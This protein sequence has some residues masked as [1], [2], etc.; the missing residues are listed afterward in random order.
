MYACTQIR[1]SPKTDFFEIARRSS[2]VA[3]E[4]R[5]RGRQRETGIIASPAA[6]VVPFAWDRRISACELRAVQ[7]HDAFPAKLELMSRQELP[8]RQL[9]TTELAFTTLGLGTWAIGGGDWQFGWGPQD[10]REAIA[11][12]QRAVELG[13]NWID[14]AAVYGGGR[15]EELVGRAIASVPRQDRPYIATK[16]GRKVRSDGSVYGEIKRHSVLA[17]CDASL[18]R[19]DVDVIDLYQL[20]WP[21]PE[22]DIE[23]AWTSMAE[24]VQAGKVRHIG[25]SNHSVAQM[26][27]L[28]T[29]HPIASLQPPYSMVVRDAETELL[30]YCRQQG[31]GVVTYSPLYKG[32]LTGSFSPARVASLGADDHRSRDPRFHEP[33]LSVHL[34]LVDQLRQIAAEQGRTPGELAIAWI[35]RRPEI[36]SAIVGARRPAQID[37]LVAGG[38]WEFDEKVAARLDAALSDHASKLADS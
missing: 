27:R 6:V 34:A 7:D 14:T 37:A 19:L 11:T 16:C 2:Q 29:I 17:E 25:V 24:L 3:E 9:G 5:G 23:E 18:S 36:T 28:A 12:I 30:P 4:E 26:R 31:I 21:L 35:L 8:V 32:L 20:H 10:E 38:A 15:S 22:E 33:A 13:I 1:Q